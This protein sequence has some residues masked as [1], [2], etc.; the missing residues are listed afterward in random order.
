VGAT[1]TAC[2]TNSKISYLK[3]IQFDTKSDNF[4]VSLLDQRP[5]AKSEYAANGFA[6]A[7]LSDFLELITA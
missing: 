1:K 5:L 6:Y 7:R 3:Q 2:P 4:P